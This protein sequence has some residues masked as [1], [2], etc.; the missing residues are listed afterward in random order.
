MIGQECMIHLMYRLVQ[1]FSNL[2][3][4]S[5]HQSRPTSFVGCFLFIAILLPVF[6]GFSPSLFLYV[7]AMLRSSDLCM[8][9]D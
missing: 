4:A 7:I 8:D 3:C 9:T 2:D 5:Y 6:I 1:L